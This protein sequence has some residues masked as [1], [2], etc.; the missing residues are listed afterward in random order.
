MQI[1]LS[2]YSKG[3]LFASIFVLLCFSLIWSKEDYTVQIIITVFRHSKIKTPFRQRSNKYRNYKNV[4]N[5]F[6]K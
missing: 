5:K 4:L 2:A 1:F 6:N 3:K